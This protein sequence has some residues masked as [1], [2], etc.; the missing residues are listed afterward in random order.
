MSQQSRYDD[1][2]RQE[3]R[4]WGDARPD[5]ANPQIWQDERLFEIF[6]GEEY[7]RLIHCAVA[8]GPDVLELG[9]GE[10]GLSLTLVKKGCRVTGLDL[11]EKRIARAAAKSAELG[12]SARTTFS[13]ADLNRV[14]LPHQAFSCVV[15]HDSLHHILHFDHLISEVQ[16]ALMPGGTIVVLDYCGMGR[17]R[18][19][20]AAGLTALL[21]T[22]QPYSAKW[23]S[24]KH[25]GSFLAGEESKRHGLNTGDRSR[26]HSESP[27]EGISQ[28]SLIRTLYANFE[29]VRFKTFLPFWFYLAPKI[30]LGNYLRPVTGRLFR[31]L[32]NGF[33]TLGVRGA[34]FAFEGRVP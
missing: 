22:Y 25:L 10:G 28:V 11:S 12:L 33:S 19:I 29:T 9:C 7:R 2:I 23:Q 13:V 15:A 20:L 26:L 31:S 17:L 24:R 3:A 27:F 8:H 1:Y 32:D 4:S 14:E 6:F 34:Y 30:R 21:P 18:K 16:K 5:A